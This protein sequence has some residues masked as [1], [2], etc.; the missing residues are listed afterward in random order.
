M[1]ELEDLDPM[2]FGKHRG[3]PMQEVPAAYLHWLWFNGKDR[4]FDCPVHDYIKRN[5]YALEEE[6]PDLEWH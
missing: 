2:P 6:T 5:M 1:R 4:E 3:K